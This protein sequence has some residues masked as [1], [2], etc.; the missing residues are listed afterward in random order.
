MSDLHIPWKIVPQDWKNSRVQ[1]ID[2]LGFEICE[3]SPFDEEWTPDEIARVSLIVAAP[4]LLEAAKW[5]ESGGPGT[6]GRW[7]NLIAAI[8]KAEGRQ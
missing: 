4:E 1:I 3:A 5:L 2:S 6:D 7:N 8:A